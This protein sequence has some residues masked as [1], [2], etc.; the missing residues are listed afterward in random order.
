[1]PPRWVRCGPHGLLVNVA[2]GPLVVT[3]DLVSALKSGHLAGAVMDVT[4]P[5]PLPSESRLWDL[6]NVVITPHVGGQSSWRIDNMT[7]LFCRNLRRWQAG[8]PLVNY[9]SG[10]AAWVSHPRWGVSALGGTVRAVVDAASC[11]V[12]DL[13][14]AA[15][16]RRHNRGVAQLRSL[17]PA[18]RRAGCGESVNMHP[19]CGVTNVNDDFP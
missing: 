3:A 9:F 19:D 16:C 18:G 10:Q 5:E 8:L 15:V 17:R 6:P 11:R 4:E 7:R 2:R 12:G 14:N 1:M 13:A